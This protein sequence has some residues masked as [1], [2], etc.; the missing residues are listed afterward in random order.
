MSRNQTDER[1]KYYLNANQ[2]ARERFVADILP[3]LGP[4]VNCKPYRPDGGPD[5]GIDIIAEL[6][7]QKGTVLVAVGFKN[8][9]GPAKIDRPWVCKKFRYDFNQAKK[10]GIAGKGF[11]FVTNV[12]LTPKNKI[13]LKTE[14][15]KCGFGHVEI[16]DREQIRLALDKPEGFFIR[17]RYLD[18]PMTTEDQ[19]RL[20]ASVG[21]ELNQLTVRIRTIESQM[22]RSN[23]QLSLASKVRNIGWTFTLEKLDSNHKGENGFLVVLPGFPETA[24][25]IAILQEFTISEEF[26][27][28]STHVWLWKHDIE[29]EIH[30]LSTAQTIDSYE[31]QLFV[32]MMFNWPLNNQPTI[33]SLLTNYFRVFASENISKN[34]SSMSL[35]INDLLIVDTV[36]PSPFI[37]PATSQ[38]RWA[39]KVPKRFKSVKWSALAAEM[40]N[41][42]LQATSPRAPLPSAQMKRN[43][44]KEIIYKLK[45]N[46]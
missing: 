17:L 14:A 38:P 32:S 12:D 31:S 28:L 26:K 41:E 6:S 2:G 16:Y 36:I 44:K 34:I 1:L 9:A 43:D 33:Y 35:V 46:R 21:I 45:S 30:L 42:V 7:D 15:I 39:G 27:S 8:D 13:K 4:Y 10:S 40:T 5:G 11:V 29:K 22:H 20:L 3:Q 23:L 25:S 24:P 37:Y 19:Y 18:I